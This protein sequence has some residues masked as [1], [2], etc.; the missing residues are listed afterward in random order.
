MKVDAVFEGGGMKFIGLV[1]AA[2]CLEDRGKLTIRARY[3]S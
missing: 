1:G 2:C 3:K